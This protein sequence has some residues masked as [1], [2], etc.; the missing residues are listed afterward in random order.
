MTFKAHIL[1]ILLCF[2]VNVF[3]AQNTN[4]CRTDLHDF[5][6]GGN[7]TYTFCF[8]KKLNIQKGLKEDCIIENNYLKTIFD[9]AVINDRGLNLKKQSYC[10][11]SGWFN[12]S[13]ISVDTS[14]NTMQYALYVI[15]FY[16]K[17]I[18]MQKYISLLQSKSYDIVYPVTKASMICYLFMKGELLIIISHELILNLSDMMVTN[19]DDKINIKKVNELD[20]EKLIEIIKE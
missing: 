8:D 14:L 15:S 1:V 10:V 5:Y 6:D 19:L 7:I 13:C 3:M 2:Q 11:N 17:D 16:K 12:T 20:I 18:A 4:L 9:G